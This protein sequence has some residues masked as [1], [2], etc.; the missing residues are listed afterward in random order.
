VYTWGGNATDATITGLPASGISFV[1]NA[2]AKTITISGTPTANVS[3]TVNTIG[4]GLSV[5]AAGT[6]TVTTVTTSGDQIHNFT[7]S[8]KISSFYTITGNIN[9]TNGLVTYNGLTLTNRLKMESSTSIRYTTIAA[10]TL[11]LVFDSN[12]TGTI[13]VNN[14]SYTAVAG[15]VT[16]TL[17]AGIYTITKGSVAN[18]FYIRT[19]YNVAARM[20]GS[21][22][23]LASEPVKNNETLSVVVYPNPVTNTLYF[24]NAT[25]KIER[26]SV[27]NMA[28]AVVKSAGNNA[29]SVDM[30]DLSAGTYLVKVITDQGTLDKVIIKK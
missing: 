22:N 23:G 20:V 5:S 3:Y 8:G 21:T 4:A 14:V 25:E 24:A 29:E 2:T 11:T 1:K 28:G 15:I 18:L 12:F 19:R 17:P 7:T 10:S 26:V 27:Y 30:N 6:I 16:V 9:A 13:R